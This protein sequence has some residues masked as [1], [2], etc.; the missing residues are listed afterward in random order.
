MNDTKNFLI[1]GGG[2]GI[3]AEVAKLL[4]SAGHRLTTASRSAISNSFDHIQFDALKD[5]L[6][7]SRLPEKLALKDELPVSRLPEKLDGLVYCPGAI[8]LKPIARITDEEFKQ[9]YDLNV[10]GFVRVLRTVLPLLKKSSS[11]SIVLYSTVAVQQGMPFHAS[12]AA[13]KGAV[14]GLTRSLAAELAPRIRVNC[15]APSLVNTPLAAKLL[16]SEDKKK[17]SDERHP[18]KRIGEAIDI[19]QLS[20][21]LLSDA[22]SWISGQIIHADGGLSTL[23]V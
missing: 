15:I 13:A 8:N 9:E 2:S 18:L 22:S 4:N 12:V 17:A 14:E 16:S 3:G 6:P 11:A 20:A 5:E 21:F 23:R 1:I 10:L 19:A 7:V